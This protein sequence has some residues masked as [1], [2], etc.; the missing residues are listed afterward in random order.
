MRKKMS[1]RPTRK[2]KEFYDATLINIPLWAPVATCCI[3]SA[4]I[5]YGRCVQYLTM[6]VCVPGVHVCSNTHRDEEKKSRWSLVVG[7]GG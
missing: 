4:R 6:C 2:N 3:N 7:A 1:K 5:I